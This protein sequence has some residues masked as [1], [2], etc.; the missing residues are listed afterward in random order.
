MA[1][2]RQGHRLHMLLSL[3]KRCAIAKEIETHL[4][5]ERRLAGRRGTQVE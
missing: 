3:V 4:V 5:L 2:Q 1:E